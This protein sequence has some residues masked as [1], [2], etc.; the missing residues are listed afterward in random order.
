MGSIRMQQEN[1]VRCRVGVVGDSGVGK[2]SLVARFFGKEFDQDALPQTPEAVT[3]T[4][5]VGCKT[6]Q[7]TIQEISNISD[8]EVSPTLYELDVIL[9]CYN[10]SQPSTIQSLIT[11]WVPSLNLLAPSTPLLLIGCQSDLRTD[12]AV[13]TS[14]AR[15]GRSPVS[16]CQGLRVSRQIRAVMYVET[17]TRHSDKSAAA[18]FE[19]AA[20][21]CMGHFNI[22]PPTA[23]HRSRSVT[24]REKAE[25]TSDFW[26]KFRS[27]I[28][29]RRWSTKSP[30]R[31]NELTSTGMKSGSMSNLSLIRSKS[32]PL[33]DTNVLSINTSSKPPRAS[34]KNSLKDQ[35]PKLKMIKCQRMTGDKTCEEIEIAVP[36]SV[37]DNL[38]QDGEI[39]RNTE[40]R[41]S[42]GRK[43]RGF[44]LKE[45]GGGCS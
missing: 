16:S 2:T 29:K 3:K 37:Y 22:P 4:T 14:L 31:L 36:E 42:F 41:Q 26:E 20:L 18:A 24:T 1:S 9:L 5:I 19:V 17:E 35:P 25:S 8:T 11:H 15:Q 32:S 40:E 39:T 33:S 34:R 6:V 30:A 13:V 27:P 23:K 12:R 21:T 44:F 43:L 10:I 28:P 38:E 45:L 7:F